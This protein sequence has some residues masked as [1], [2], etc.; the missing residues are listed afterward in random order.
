MLTYYRIEFRLR[1]GSSRGNTVAFPYLDRKDESAIVAA[2]LVNRGLLE[3]VA[4][5]GASSDDFFYCVKWLNLA[6][7]G[8]VERRIAGTF[9]PDVWPYVRFYYREVVIALLPLDLSAYV[10]MWILEWLPEFRVA[11]CD[12]RKIELI[13]GFVTSRRRLMNG[14]GANANKESRS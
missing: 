13:A 4:R 11:R 9:G 8:E 12:R 6:Y 5:E 10:F 3:R 2:H 1:D 7:P 14:R